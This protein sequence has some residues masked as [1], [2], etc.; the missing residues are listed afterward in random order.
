M[1]G[2]YDYTSSTIRDLI[3]QMEREM[4]K[5]AEEC[6]SLRKE[7]AKK[8]FMLEQ[9]ATRIAVLEDQCKKS[10]DEFAAAQRDLDLARKERAKIASILGFD[11]AEIE[12]ARSSLKT[13]VPDPAVAATPTPAPLPEIE[14]SSYAAAAS[15]KESGDLYGFVSAALDRMRGLNSTLPRI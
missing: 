15:S 9:A 5:K 6:A 14:P 13:S 7:I 2:Y 3:G 8:D 11:D 10:Q 4:E 12:A 1:G